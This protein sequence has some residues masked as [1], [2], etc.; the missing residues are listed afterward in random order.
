MSKIGIYIVVVIYV[1]IGI[2]ISLTKHFL[3][4]NKG[5]FTCII[6]QTG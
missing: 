1:G 3:V 2:F 6:P 4:S 5:S